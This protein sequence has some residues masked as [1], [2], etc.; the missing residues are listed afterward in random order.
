MT[1]TM[2]RPKWKC[3]ISRCVQMRLLMIV[4]AVLT[5]TMVSQMIQVTNAG[6]CGGNGEC[7]CDIFPFDGCS[8]PQNCEIGKRNRRQ[9]GLWRILW[10]Q[11]YDCVIFQSAATTP[12]AP[13]N[14]IHWRRTKWS[15]SQLRAAMMWWEWLIRQSTAS[16]TLL[17]QTVDIIYGQNGVVHS[18]VDIFIDAYVCVP[19]GCTWPVPL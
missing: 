15:H 3:D 16:W 2:L 19:S 11:F 1:A 8:C 10:L 17:T 18:L 14:E 5:V 6:W 13:T 9:I 12:H 4:F 7:K